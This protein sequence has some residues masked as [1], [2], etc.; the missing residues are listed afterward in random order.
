MP[1]QKFTFR[2]YVW[3]ICLEIMFGFT[4][5]P[6]SKKEIL[7]K[8]ETRI[9]PKIIDKKNSPSRGNPD[10]AKSLQGFAKNPE[11]RTKK[12]KN[13]ISWIFFTQKRMTKNH[14]GWHGWHFLVG[15]CRPK[16]L[17]G[18]VF[19]SVIFYGLDPIGWNSPSFGLPCGRIS[20]GSLFSSH[21]SSRVA[22]LRKVYFFHN[23]LHF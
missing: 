4:F 12:T 2:N 23:F 22:N 20:L 16:P 19:D 10:T 8:S 15:K 6:T 14:Q 5:D 13:T 11:V 3:N 9:L 7:R 1:Q 18:F 21:A 17:L